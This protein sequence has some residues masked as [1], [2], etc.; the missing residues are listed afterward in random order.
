MFPKLKEIYDDV[1]TTAHNAMEQLSAI[2]KTEFQ[3]CFQHPTLNHMSTVLKA[4]GI[5]LVADLSWV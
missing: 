4:Q 5:L 2:P 3:I 1:E